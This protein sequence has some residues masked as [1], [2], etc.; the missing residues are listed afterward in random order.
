M[1][2]NQ[3]GDG[4]F[5]ANANA[6]KKAMQQKNLKKASQ[7]VEAIGH[8]DGC[9]YR[10]ILLMINL[11]SK[12]R[13]NKKCLQAVADVLGLKLNEII[14]DDIVPERFA[15]LEFDGTKLKVVLAVIQTFIEGGY[16]QVKMRFARIDP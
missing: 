13:H 11:E 16:D 9:G 10:K 15:E 4:F 2:N 7:I 5:R 1:K 6:I 14:L 8:I 3:I 12:A